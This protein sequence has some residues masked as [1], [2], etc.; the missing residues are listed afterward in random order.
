MVIGREFRKWIWATWYLPTNWLLWVSY[1]V[2][3]NIFFCKFF[4]GDHHWGVDGSLYIIWHHLIIIPRRQRIKAF[5]VGIMRPIARYY[6]MCKYARDNN[7][8]VIVYKFAFVVGIIVVAVNFIICLFLLLLLF[9][10][11]FVCLSFGSFFMIFQWI[12]LVWS[13]KV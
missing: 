8:L 1:R 13:S 10:C 11:L 3:I 2:S 4:F 7:L 9:V 5:L 6:L 12:L